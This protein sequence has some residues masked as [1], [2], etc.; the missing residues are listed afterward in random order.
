[1]PTYT[2]TKTATERLSGLCH[3]PFRSNYV[4]NKIGLTADEWGLL[5][6]VGAQLFPFLK[7]DQRPSRSMIIAAL[8]D[9]ADRRMFAGERC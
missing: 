3:R 8:V 2:K 5:D 7:A 6:R 9:R 1:M 4:R